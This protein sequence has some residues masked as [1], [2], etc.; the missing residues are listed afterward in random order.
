MEELVRLREVLAPVGVYVLYW[1]GKAVFVGKSINLFGRL[2]THLQQLRRAREGK[3]IYSGKG[4]VIEFDDCAVQWCGVEDLNRIERELI[5]RLQPEHNIDH[6]PPISIAHLPSMKEL[7]N[8]Q[9]RG[10]VVAR[11]RIVQT[12]MPKRRV[13]RNQWGQRRM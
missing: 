11:R 9:R 13:E 6:T 12:M 7:L 8:R 1:R 3:S 4:P 2:A 10:P 5:Q